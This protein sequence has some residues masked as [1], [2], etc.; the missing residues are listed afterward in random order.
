[1]QSFRNQK[2]YEIHQVFW[3]TFHY[4]AITK[5]P[6]F[7]PLFHP[8]SHLFN[9]GRPSPSNVQ[10]ITSTTPLSPLPPPPTPPPPI[11]TVTTFTTTSH[12]NSKFCDFIVLQP[13]VTSPCKHHNVLSTFP[14]LIP[15]QTNAINHEER[16]VNFT[17]K[18][19]KPPNRGHP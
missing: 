7:G 18:K 8:C 10:N 13:V 2:C 19:V 15:I 3:G 16:F 11:T 5:C 6:K 17:S 12:R 4:Y 1:M 14:K 9:F